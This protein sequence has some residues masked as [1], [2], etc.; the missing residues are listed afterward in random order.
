MGLIL[1]PSAVYVLGVGGLTIACLAYMSIALAWSYMWV[2][3]FQGPEFRRNLFFLDMGDPVL[4]ALW[5]GASVIV[6]PCTTLIPGLMGVGALVASFYFL[7]F[8]IFP[9]IFPCGVF[10]RGIRTKLKE[11][12]YAF[13]TGI[14]SQISEKLQSSKMIR[15]Y[16]APS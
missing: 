12:A 2:L 9:L 5:L 3:I 15:M 16:H 6:A 7:F 13:V 14:G 1:R 8:E 4:D 11:G 10:K